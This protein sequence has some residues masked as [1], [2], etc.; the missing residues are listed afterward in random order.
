MIYN[1]NNSFY[2]LVIKEDRIIKNQ[3]QHVRLTNQ[4]S[5]LMSLGEFTF[6]RD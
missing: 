1:G 3:I 6:N 2:D 4:F 5:L